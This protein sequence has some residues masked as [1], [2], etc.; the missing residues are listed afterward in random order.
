MY[1]QVVPEQIYDEY[2]IEL[3]T[4]EVIHFPFEL[5]TYTAERAFIRRLSHVEQQTADDEQRELLSRTAEALAQIYVEA[6]PGQTV[7]SFSMNRVHIRLTGDEDTYTTSVIP[8]FRKEF[9]Q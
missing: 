2:L 3:D 8:L 7:H 6:N 1:S 4:G 5:I 9:P